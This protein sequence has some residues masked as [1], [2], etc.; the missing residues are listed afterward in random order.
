MSQ[1][2]LVE[3]TSSSRYVRNLAEDP[4]DVGLGTAIWGAVVIG[5]IKMCDAQ[6]E[7]SPQDCTQSFKWPV[8][9]EVLP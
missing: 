2:A 1:P 8:I 5:Q 6:V 4:P 9:T 7:G 3:M